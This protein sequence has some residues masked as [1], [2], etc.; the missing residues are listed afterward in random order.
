MNVTT[1][2]PAGQHWRIME[3]CMATKDKIGG[4]YLASIST[5]T[6]CEWIQA[7]RDATPKTLL[8]ALTG[9]GLPADSYGPG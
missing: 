2:H 5:E 7:E 8:E 6:Q 3:L 4:Y 1:K 9:L